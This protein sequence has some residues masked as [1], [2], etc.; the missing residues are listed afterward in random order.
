MAKNPENPMMLFESAHDW[1]TWLKKNHSTSSNGV[2][3][4]ISKKGSGIRTVTYAEAVDVALCYGWIDGLKQ[5]HDD[6]FFLQTFTPRRAKSVWSKINTEKVTRLI[7]EGR[8]QP[9]GLKEIEAA[10]QDGRWDAAYESQRNLQVPEDFQAA[11]D[12]NPKAKAF[13]ATLNSSNRYSLCFR[14]QTAK[15]P[16]TRRARIEKFIGILNNQEKLH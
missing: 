6:T 12:R 3:L 13:F 11:L 10:K 15:K 2:R 8:M 14:I 7:A 4:Q 1:E 9:A 5:A 16:E